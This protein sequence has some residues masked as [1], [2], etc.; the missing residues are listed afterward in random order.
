MKRVL[1]AGASGYLGQHMVNSLKEQGYWVRVLVRSKKQVE[2]FSPIADEVYLGEVTRPESLKGLCIDIDWVFSSV[3]ITRQKDSLSYMDVDY[4]GNINLLNEAINFDV[5]KFMYI[6]TAKRSHMQNV[7]IIQ[8]KEKFVTELKKSEIEKIIIRPNG[9]F[10]DMKEF[11]NMAKSGIIFLAGNG[12]YKVTPIS[13][14]DLSAFCVGKFIDTQAE[15]YELGGPQTLSH[16]ELGDICF[17]SIKKRPRYVKIPVSII[18]FIRFIIPKVTSEKFYGPLEFFLNAL[19][20]DLTSPEYG[21]YTYEQYIKNE[22]N[23]KS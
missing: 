18:K 21:K 22:V 1:V 23:K 8:A 2:R 17:G 7:K 19:T 3:G 4:Q 10:S 6:A 5:K 16:R 20:M 14:E 13:G 9:F 11:L 12:N 15:E